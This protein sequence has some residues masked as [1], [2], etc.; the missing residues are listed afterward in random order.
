MF[1]FFRNKA[2]DDELEE[3][4]TLASITYLIKKGEKGALIDVQLSDFENE[5]VEAL[6]SILEILGNDT[7]YIDTIEMIRT[8][9]NKEGR[10]DVLANVLSRTELKIRQKIIDSAKNRLKDEPCIKPSEMFK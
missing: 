5:S 4:N 10:Y 1:N 2:E 9:L 6:S 7:F 3:D 8:S